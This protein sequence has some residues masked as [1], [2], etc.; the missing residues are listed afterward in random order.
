VSCA[1]ERLLTQY[2]TTARL[3]VAA[4]ELSVVGHYYPVTGTVVLVDAHASRLAGTWC[5]EWDTIAQPEQLF[6]ERGSREQLSKR[7]KGRHL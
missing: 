4:T 2:P 3:S 7:L 1:A 5:G 6:T